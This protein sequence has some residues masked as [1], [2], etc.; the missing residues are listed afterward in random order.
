[1]ISDKEFQKIKRAMLQPKPCILCMK[2]RAEKQGA[3][4][5]FKAEE[6]GGK[7]GK[8][9]AIVYGLCETRFARP[10]SIEAVEAALSIDR[11]TP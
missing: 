6:Y 11:Q 8:G 7:P 5:P 10:D 3:F 1:M 2:A 9:R 4:L